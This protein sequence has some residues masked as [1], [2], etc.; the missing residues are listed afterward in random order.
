MFKTKKVFSLAGIVIAC[1]LVLTACSGKKQG[2]SGNSSS[3][4]KNSVALITDGNGVNDHSFNQSAWNGFLAYGKAH[5]LSRGKNGYQYFQT[6]GP[7]DFVPN[8]DE[9]V[10]AGYQTIFGVGYSLKDAISSEAKK[11][12]KKNF[13]IIDDQIKGQKNV[14]SANFKSQDASYLAGVVAAKTTKSG[15]VGF[16]GGAHGDIVDLFD[17]GF[18]QGVRDTAKKMGKKITILNQYIGNFTSSDKAKSIAQSMYAKKADIIFHAA[19]GAGDGLFQEAKALNQTRPAD[20]KVWVIGVDVDQSNLGNYSA[21]GGQKSNF[22]LTSVI[23]GVNVATK[24]IAD[25]AYQGKFP[26]GKDLIFGLENDG[27]SITNG[28]VSTS[29]W[30]AARQARCQILKSEIKVAIHPKNN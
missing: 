14:A 18:A 16:I 6:S 19:G 25:L 12:P 1:G 20:K 10:N 26:G 23:T 4:A 24:K 5:N 29:A 28:Q 11:Y 30:K 17:A 2:G 7:S 13:V 22:V 8:I 15:V 21:K 3:N 27:V 9:A